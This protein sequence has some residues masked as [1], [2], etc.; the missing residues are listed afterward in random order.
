MHDF[1]YR[2]LTLDSYFDKI[3][4]I[5]LTRDIDRNEHMISQFQKF[6]IKNY[7]RIEAQQVD[8]L[9]ELSKYRNFIKDTPEYIKGSIGCRASH[10]KCVKLAKERCYQRVLILEDDILFTENPDKLLTINNDVLND[11]DI[12]YFGGL[13]EHFFRNQ[14]VCSHAYAL[15]RSVFDDIINIAEVSGMEIDNFY[16]KILQHMSYNHNQSGKYNVRIIMPFNLIVQEKKFN[17]NI[18]E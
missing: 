4:Y 17:T 8:M 3:F 2:P 16:A 12:L 10:L 15:K 7:E 14:I 9:P 18:Q 11:W 6:G 1:T 5:N 13:I